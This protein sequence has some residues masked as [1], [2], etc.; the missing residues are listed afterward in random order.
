MPNRKPAADSEVEAAARLSAILKGAFKGPPT[1]L[2][3][4]PKKN[5]ESRL[6][7][8]AATKKRRT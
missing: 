8:G 2:K 1:P 4:I 3:A 6:A 5:G 7:P